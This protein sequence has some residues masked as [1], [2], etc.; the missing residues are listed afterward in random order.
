MMFYEFECGL[1][2][3]LSM[4]V[5]IDKEEGKVSMADGS[6]WRLND[7]EIDAIIKRIKL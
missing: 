2:I 7:K 3:N 1:I 6:V 4:I 5:E